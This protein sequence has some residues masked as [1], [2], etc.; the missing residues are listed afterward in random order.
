MIIPDIKDD[1]EV[2][3]Y[4]LKIT[5]SLKDYPMVEASAIQYGLRVYYPCETMTG[6]S[7]SVFQLSTYVDRTIYVT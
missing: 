2:G 3:Y 5:T 4:N 6:Y 7:P 1:F